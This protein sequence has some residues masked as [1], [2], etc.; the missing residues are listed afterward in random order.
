MVRRSSSAFRLA[1][2]GLCMGVVFAS[3]VRV[4]VDIGPT[5]GEDL[6][7]VTLEGREA[8]KVLVIP[9]RGFLSDDPKAG[10][11][12][13][14]P[15]TVQ[16]IVAQLRL[17]EKDDE[18]KA[19]LLEIDSPGG[20]VTASD[21]LYHEIMRFKEKRGVKVV[22]A[23]L[24]VAASGGYYVAQSSDLIVA[25]PTSITGSVGVIFMTPKVVGLMEKLG[26]GV[27]VSKSGKEKDIGSPF[28]ASTADE[29]R[30][31]Q[32]LTDDLAGRFLTLVRTHR[33]LS[34]SAYTEISTGRIFAGREALELGL[35][36]RI[37]YLADALAA[38]RALAGL[39]EDARVVAYRHRKQEH[40]NLYNTAAAMNGSAGMSLIDLNL[41]KVLPSLGPGFY[42]LWL[43]AGEGK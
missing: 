30:I 20:T 21:I 3:C 4:R 25:H 9:V 33:K 31:F 28:R 23:F 24:D 18:I 26:V 39:P 34:A 17:A 42:Y 5:S 29:R 37:G 19:L 8:G 36:D 7:E 14:R 22:A 15:S 40:D 6:K 38:A 43:P 16:H 32:G 35:V 1:V 2:L 12:G 11:L 10:L 27:E 41:P 13:S